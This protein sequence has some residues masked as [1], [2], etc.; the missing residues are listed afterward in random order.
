MT[1][2]IPAPFTPKAE[3]LALIRQ[4]SDKIRPD[5][6]AHI[7]WYLSY[8][9]DHATRLAFDLQIIKEYVATKLAI[10]EYGAVPLLMT[11]ALMDSGYRVS[12]L[13]IA[14]ERFSTSVKKHKIDVIKC[15]IEKERTPFQDNTFD[16]IIFNELFEHLRINPI[17]T[18]KEVHRI[19]KPDGT[20]FLSTPNLRSLNGIRNF[21][22]SNLSYSCSPNIYRQFEKLET[23]GHMGH[24]REYTTREVREFLENIG[25]TTELIIFRG[26]YNKTLPQLIARQFPSLRPFATFLVKK[27]PR[28]SRLL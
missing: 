20:L 14:P 18:M 16:A 11:K 5:E 25:F 3:N 19:L 24:T 13:D 26:R 9:N 28:F 17:F 23:L 1:K 10:L 27:S 12:A 4:V 7:N 15:D 6:S 22:L 8:A 21:L 2:H